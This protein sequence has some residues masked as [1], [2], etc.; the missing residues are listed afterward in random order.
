M[1]SSLA[2]SSLPPRSEPMPLFLLG[3]RSDH[4]SRP[5]QNTPALVTGALQIARW[6]FMFTGHGLVLITSSRL[7]LQQSA[8]FCVFL[9]P[10]ASALPIK[11]GRPSVLSRRLFGKRIA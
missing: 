11:R 2:D 5:P 6:Q 10:R 1:N 7:H 9:C 8:F 3:A 4:S